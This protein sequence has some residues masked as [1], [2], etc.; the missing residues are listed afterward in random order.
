MNSLLYTVHSINKE[1]KGGGNIVRQRQ[2]F[3][4]CRGSL[5]P[6]TKKGRI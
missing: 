3:D 5:D 6:S 1:K 4:T 2:C